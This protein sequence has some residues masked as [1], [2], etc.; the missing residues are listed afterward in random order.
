MT[1][2]AEEPEFALTATDINGAVWNKLSKHMESKLL[3]LRIKNDSDMDPVKTAAVRGEIRN[4]KNLLALGIP[5]PEMVAD[6]E[7]PE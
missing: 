2:P 6:E 4:L 7:P 5:A 3:A 1:K